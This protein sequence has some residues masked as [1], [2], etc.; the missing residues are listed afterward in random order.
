MNEQVGLGRHLGK[1]TL[2]RDTSPARLSL[3]W[4][5][6]GHPGGHRHL[7]ASARSG[8]AIETRE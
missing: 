5:I 6:A 4:A 8:M 7:R 1:A 3:H 2:H